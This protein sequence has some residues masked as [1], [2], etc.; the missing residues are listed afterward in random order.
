[1]C[2]ERIE[3]PCR[4]VSAKKQGVKCRFLSPLLQSD[5][6]IL[7]RKSMMFSEKYILK[8]FSTVERYNNQDKHL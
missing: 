2:L 6:E 3:L 4:N 1:M 8:S 7:V 5:K